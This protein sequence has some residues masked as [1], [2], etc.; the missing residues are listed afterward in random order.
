MLALGGAE[1]LAVPT[2][3]PV[4]ERPAGERPPVVTIAMA[5]ARVN[6]VFVACCD[7][8]GTERGQEWT[9]GTAIIDRMG[10][11]LSEQTEVGPASAEVELALARDKTLTQL[12]DAL[13]DRRPEL[14]RGLAA[15]DA[16]P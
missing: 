5:T 4:M 10:W 8:T 7:R 12:C 13:G 6:R 14:Y 16:E 11:V 9:A 15:T 1:L 2:N 3:W